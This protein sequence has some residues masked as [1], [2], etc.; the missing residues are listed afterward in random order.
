MANINEAV[1]HYFRLHNAEAVD[2]DTVSQFICGD[3]SSCHGSRGPVLYHKMARRALA[4]CLV[5]PALYLCALSSAFGASEGKRGA[6]ARLRGASSASTCLYSLS[7][8]FNATV[9]YSAVGMIVGWWRHVTDMQACAV[10]VFVGRSLCGRGP[11]LCL[12]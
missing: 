3:S 7:C 12:F 1:M 2:Y 5:F 4:F 8:T 10:L 11:R 6:P 9:Q